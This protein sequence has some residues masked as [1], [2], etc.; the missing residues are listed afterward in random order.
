MALTRQL[1]V[2]LAAAALLTLATS[3]VAHAQAASAGVYTLDQ[4]A[5]QIDF[6]IYASAIFKVKREG[7][8]KDFSGELSY[9]PGSPSS[10]RVDL[11][12]FTD[13]VD[14]HNEEHDRLLRSGDFFDV[15]HFPTM[16]FASS[17]ADIKPDGS[18]EVTGD[19]TIRGIT[20]RLTIPVRLH[21]ADLSSPASPE[22][23]ESTFQID[24]TDF[25]INGVP[26]MKGFKVS[27]SKKVQIHIAIAPAASTFQPTH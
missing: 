26:N 17:S 13:S 3:S 11:T 18:L 12:V 15:E 5:S 22:V 10:T 8:F 2:L 9:D 7:Q 4:T 24:R 1:P 21:H 6:T 25:G 19:M 16:H 14:M 23:F 20:H 27:I